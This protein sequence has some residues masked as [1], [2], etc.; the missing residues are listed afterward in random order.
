[1]DQKHFIQVTQGGATRDVVWKCLLCKGRATTNIIKHSMTDQ[2]KAYVKDIER[3]QFQHAD[4][5]NSGRS[6]S[7]TGFNIEKDNNDFNEIRDSSKG[8]FS[9]KDYTDSDSTSD[10]EILNDSQSEV[11]SSSLKIQGDGDSM[12]DLLIGQD[13]NLDYQCDQSYWFP[14]K[15]KEIMIGCLIAGCTRTLMSRKTY[16]HIQVVLRLCDLQLPSWKTELGNP[17]VAKY[18]DF[19]PE[20]SEGENIYKLSQC[21][22]W[23]HQYPRDLRAQMIRVGDQS[24]YIYE[25]AQI[26]DRNV[27][28][29]LYFYNKG[30]KLWAKVCKLNVLVLPSSLVELSISGDLNFYSSN[31]KEIMA[32]DFLKPYH[33]I[34][35]NDGRPLKSICRNELY[36]ITPE[37][38]EIIKLPNPWRLKAQGRMIRHV[39]LSIYSDDT[40]G[41]LSKQ[42]NKHISI[43]MSL[44]GLTPHISN[45]EYNTLFV[46]TSNIATALELAAPV[47]EELNILSKSGFFTFDYSLQ[48]DVL[49]L[50]VILIFLGDSPMHAEITSTLHPNVSLQPCRICKLKAKNKKD[51]ATGTYVDNFI[52]RNTNGI[53]VKPNLRSWI[54]TKKAAYLTWYL[55]QRGAPKTQVQ[56]CISEFGVKDVLNQTIIHTIKENQDTKVTYNIRRLQDDSIGKLFNPFYELKGFD[57]HKD[58]PV[59]VLHVILLGIVKYLYCDFICGLTVDKKEELVAR[60]QSFDI[61]NLNIPSIKAKYLVQHYSSLVGKDFKIIIQAAPFVFFTIIE[62]SRQKIWIS[63]CHLC[64][65][66]FQTHISCLENYVANLNS[67]TQDFLIKLISSNAQWV[68]KPKFHILLHLSQS[69]ARFGPASLFAT[70]KYCL[71]GGNCI[72]ET[73]ISIVSPSYQVK[74]LLLKNPT[75]QNLLGLDSYIFKV[76]PSCTTPKGI[77]SIS[78]NSDW[79][80]ILLF[81]LEDHQTIKANS[82]VSIKAQQANKNNFIA[83]IIG[84]WGKIYIHCMHCEMLE[85]DPLYGMRTLKKLN[86]EDF[87]SAKSIISGLNVQHHCAGAKCLIRRTLPKRLERQ[88]TDMMLNELQ[89]NFRFNLCVINTAS[90]RAQDKHHAPARI[91]TPQI[92]PLQALNAVHDG[93]SEWKKNNNRKGKNKAAESVTSIDPSL[94]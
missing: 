65:L 23:L 7:L 14:F 38:T 25:P 91:T 6:H 67:F 77:K 8:G 9:K 78:P 75:I 68:D 51:K 71:S 58:T 79:I 30:N 46:A 18:L 64:S 49:V 42:W 85:V 76:K 94:P 13:D 62:E 59:E 22:K 31:M 88:E 56:S 54:D 24:F 72:S 73:N 19:Y 16:N 35:F 33:E 3:W 66:I 12:E 47:V 87:I 40:S 81:E 17:I 57:G 70:E 15:K 53:L 86:R 89:H 34:T 50:P 60:F 93:L 29:P 10:G 44:V 1:M 32:E 90:L 69:V 5:S 52:G 28:V 11:S 55:V 63:L 92:Q 36:E 21:E 84:I 2:H 80:N 41:N 39:P 4:L 27:V 82:F 61:S 74:N 83:F 43:F 45:Q 20:N 37:R 48:E 26:I